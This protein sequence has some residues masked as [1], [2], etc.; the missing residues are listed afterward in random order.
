MSNKLKCEIY[1]LQ[2]TSAVAIISRIILIQLVSVNQKQGGFAKAVQGFT[3]KHI[4]FSVYFFHL[5]QDLPNL[6]LSQGNLY[7]T[8]F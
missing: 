3:Q 1:P 8:S 2:T 5:R 4:R 6:P 7:K